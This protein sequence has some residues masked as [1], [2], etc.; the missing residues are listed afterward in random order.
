MIISA[1]R[2]LADFENLGMIG[3]V[4]GM[5]M[6][7]PAFTPNYTAARRFVEEGMN[8][9][10]LAV[11]VD[12]VGNV[13]GRMEGEDSSLPAIY[14][15]SHLD[16]VPRGGKYDGPLGVMA[17]L[18]AA[19]TIR[20]KGLPMKHSLVVV[21]FTAEEG[22]EM[23]GTFGSR[24]FAGLLEEPLSS[25]KLAG[26]GLTPEGVRSSKADP[27][28]VA[29]YLELH[30]EQGP[31]LERRGIQIGIPTGIVGISR[32]EVSLEGEANHAGTTPMKERR[33]AMREAAELL[34]EWFA[35]TDTKDDF[36][37]NVGVLALHPG[38]VVI[39]PERV[40]FTLEIRSLKDSVMEEA[41]A[42]FR[43]LLEAREKVSVSMKPVV[44][45]GA[46]DLDPLLQ[47]A[48]EKAC[49]EAGVSFV[50]MPSG[51]SH[52]ANPMARITRAGMIF[53]PSVKGISHS[54]DEYTSPEDCARGADILARAILE[55]DRSL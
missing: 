30:I 45:K 9:A 23:G 11:Y 1:D 50:R 24:A 52:D 8:E 20:E 17:A 31:Y 29:C 22:G 44:W 26:V 18:E 37:C 2:F 13:F 32:Y 19:R 35:W 25:E 4:D 12:D 47:D 15:G 53:V 48:V 14:A 39:V 34:A 27:S 7:R 21:G 41:A 6:D 54:K 16:A 3:W 55:A 46:V 5:G 42:K 38:A 43:S 28:S 33:D 51:A 40:D 36:V 10:G 49:G